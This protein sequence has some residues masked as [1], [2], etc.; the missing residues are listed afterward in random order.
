RA[1]GECALVIA[2]RLTKKVGWPPVGEGWDSTK[3]NF[4]GLGETALVDLFTG[5]RFG[6]KT[7]AMARVFGELPFAVL[8]TEALI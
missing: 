8:T 1:E 4:A 7:A 6:D 5:R 3:V 2:P